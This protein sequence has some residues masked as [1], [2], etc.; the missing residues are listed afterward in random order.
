MD[1]ALMHID[2]YVSRLLSDRKYFDRE[3]EKYIDNC[4]T[5]HNVEGN[6]APEA[7]NA[8]I[9][10][11]KCNRKVRKILSGVLCFVDKRSISDENFR[12]LLSFRG[13]CRVTFLSNIAH[14]DLAFYQMQI[15]NQ[16]PLSFE[17]FAWLFDHISKYDFFSE[18][19]ML[20]IL[21]ENSDV[22]DAGIR[23]CID[24]ALEKYGASNKIDVAIAWLD[25]MNR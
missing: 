9:S 21:R 4:Y 18:E 7:L 17:A 13:S 16:F 1:N 10:K 11:A 20:Q 8:L 14:A 5:I 23:M 25:R 22:T 24:S 12:L 15:L 3:Y 2:E 6:I 19:D